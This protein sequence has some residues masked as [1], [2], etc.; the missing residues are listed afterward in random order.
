[1]EKL[2]LSLPPRSCSA[3]L[4]R[5]LASFCVY[6]THA[7]NLMRPELRS[8]FDRLIAFS[9]LNIFCSQFALPIFFVLSGYVLTKPFWTTRDN[10]K[11]IRQ[12]GKRWLRLYPMVALSCLI[13]WL[14]FTIKLYFNHEI[15]KVS[16][17]T[18]MNVE[19]FMPAAPQPRL[20]Q[21]IFL[22]F[23]LENEQLNPVS[24]SMRAGAYSS[25]ATLAITYLFVNLKASRIPV[26]LTFLAGFV[27]FA[28]KNH[29][30][31][32]RSWHLY[33]CMIAGSTLAYYHSRQ[34][35]STFSSK[36]L[37]AM[38]VLLLVYLL[39]IPVVPAIDGIHFWA[40]N[41][42]DVMTFLSIVLSPIA[43]HS[44]MG[45]EDWLSAKPALAKLLKTL[46]EMAFPAYLLHQPI[47]M[48]LSAGLTLVTY[49]WDSFFAFT[50]VMCSTAPVILV[51]SYTASK[52][53]LWWQSYLNDIFV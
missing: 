39:A 18:N 11:L 23:E 44:I 53:D 8:K 32:N 30:E 48:S 10:S 2:S 5:I 37:T 42:L 14:F 40:L 38:L 24:W 19:K 1:M 16:N 25:Y 31:V 15:A 51:L 49:Q 13:S 17:N 6:N 26:L 29:Y 3:D 28:H 12:W 45:L 21:A 9:P 36:F 20:A 33:A 4:I 41:H 46:G 34:S 7:V 27:L 43:V 50:T 47:F 52:L 35:K 22:G